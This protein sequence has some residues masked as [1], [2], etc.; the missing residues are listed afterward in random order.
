[1]FYSNFE[2]ME[3]ETTP[4]GEPCAQVGIDDYD[5]RTRR[6]A[7]A[8]IA[9]LH[10]HLGAPPAGVIIRVKGFPHDFG[11]YHQIVMKW[12]SDDEQAA[13]WVYNADRNWPENWDDQARVDLS[14]TLPLSAA[15]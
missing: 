6:E 8:M 11:I 10:R 13:D 14:Q 4:H 3:F 2:E 1:M 15:A 7:A 5:L 9:Q 12:R